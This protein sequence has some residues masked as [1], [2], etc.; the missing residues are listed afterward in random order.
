VL[1]GFDA[2]LRAVLKWVCVLLLTGMTIILALNI[3]VRAV[4]FMTTVWLDE[5]LEL[6]FSALIFYGAAA[7]WVM[8]GNFSVGDWISGILPNLAWRTGY[9]LLVETVSL[10]FIG[11]FFW[12]SLKLMIGTDE[13]TTTFA[14]SKKWM[15]S[16]MPIAG[17]IMMI[18]TLK[19][20]FLELFAAT[21]PQA[22]DESNG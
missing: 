2:V 17:A 18:Y 10:V 6:M 21:A 4:P 9:R 11:I 8:R 14:I 12:Y 5:I 3:V 13:V 15:Y 20:M 7:V 19:N 1:S 16:C 22:S